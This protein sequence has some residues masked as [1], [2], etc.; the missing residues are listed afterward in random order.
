ME[1]NLNQSQKIFNKNYVLLWQGAFISRMGS[2]IYGVAM[3]LYL[4]H[5]TE[6]TFIIGMFWMAAGIP[7]VLLGPISGTIADRYSR[8]KILIISDLC[9]GLIV[10]LLGLYLFNVDTST[11]NN[12][13]II[14]IFSVA[15]FFGITGAFVGPAVSAAIPDLVPKSKLA[16]A[17]SISQIAIQ[18]SSFIGL[19]IGAGLYLAF[20]V[21]AVCL[22]NGVSYF[23]ASFSRSFM[24]IPQKMPEK[25]AGLKDQFSDFKSDIIQ[26]FKYIWH[27]RGLRLL[28]YVATITNFFSTPIIALFPFYVEDFLNLGGHFYGIFM[29]ITGIGAFVGTIFAGLVRFPPKTRGLLLIFFIIIM[30]VG[31]GLL[32]FVKIPIAAVALVFL[33]GFMS[34]YIMINI[35]VTLQITTPSEI[36]GRVMAM[37]TTLVGSLMPLGM[38]L[39]GYIGDL[40]DKN[41]PLIYASCG[42]IMALL[43]LIVSF[44]KDFRE[45]LAYDENA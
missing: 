15:I 44:N 22:I 2:S 33:G 9:N 10:L 32:G 38:G 39:G 35:S 30:S 42:G 7:I 13:I 25:K 31:Y 43:T 16:P 1:N 45:F 14:G 19:S 5:L 18:V 17:N 41:I 27:H 3:A 12:L 37:L 40:L 6:S 11:F 4:K 24:I 34:G 28:V 29:G 8:K 26:G 23:Y 21:P 36:R 20:G